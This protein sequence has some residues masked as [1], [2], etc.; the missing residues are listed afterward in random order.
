MI[1]KVDVQKNGLAG[2]LGGPSPSHEPGHGEAWMKFWAVWLKP[3]HTAQHCISLIFHCLNLYTSGPNEINSE[4]SYRSL[5]P[6]FYQCALSTLLPLPKQ[7]KHFFFFTTVQHC[8]YYK[9]D[10]NPKSIRRVLCEC[11]FLVLFDFHSTGHS[12]YPNLKCFYF[13]RQS[14][15]RYIIGHLCIFMTAVWCKILQCH[16][17]KQLSYWFPDKVPFTR[18]CCT[19]RKD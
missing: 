18:C 6:W 7:N 1:V 19:D 11:L 17:T 16:Q 4:V 8:E 12:K 5:I 14:S 10:L 2:L 9:N 15:A 13:C 3:G